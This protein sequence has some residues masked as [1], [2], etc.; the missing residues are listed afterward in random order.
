MTVIMAMVAMRPV[1]M[2]AVIVTVIAMR[3]MNMAGGCQWPDRQSAGPQQAGLDKAEFLA[4]GLG[5]PFPVE[6]GL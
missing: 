4:H 5:V 3:A 2:I 1:D 6:T